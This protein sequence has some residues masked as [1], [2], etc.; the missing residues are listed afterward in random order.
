MTNSSTRRGY[1]ESI[2]R[3]RGFGF[4]ASRGESFFFR[5]HDVHGV[6]F[7]EQLVERYIS[8]VPYRR[9]AGWAAAEISPVKE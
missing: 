9:E 4:V 7:D 2:N 6:A 8:F 5:C 1:V 3:E